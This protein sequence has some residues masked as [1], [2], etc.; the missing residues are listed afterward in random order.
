[1]LCFPGKL[2]PHGKVSVQ[3][4]LFIYPKALVLYSVWKFYAKLGPSVL[5]VYCHNMRYDQKNWLTDLAESEEITEAKQLT[6][7]ES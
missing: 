3:V 5:M 7:G 4:S 2:F 1:M 6:K